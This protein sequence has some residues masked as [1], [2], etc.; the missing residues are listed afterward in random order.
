METTSRSLANRLH[1]A[2]DRTFVGRTRELARFRAALRGGHGASPVLYVHGPGGVGKSTLL[3][4]FEDEARD[5]GRRVFWVDGRR[6][7]PSPDGF[8]AEASEAVRGANIVLLVDAFEACQGLEGWLR[9][10]FLPSLPETAVVVLACRLPPGPDWSCDLAWSD[11][12]EVLSLDLL[13]ANSAGALLERRGVAPSLHDSVL[14]F[15]GGHPLALSLAA[16][17]AL[18][19][20]TKSA[21]WK[22]GPDV[23]ATLLSV[24]VGEVPSREHRLALETA[25]HALTTTETLLGAVVGEVNAAAMFAWLRNLP[26]SEY[27]RQGLFLHELVAEVLDQDFRWRDPD[28]YEQMHVRTGHHL[29]NRVRTAPEAEAMSAVRALTYLKRYG[30]MAPYFERIEREGDAYEDILRPDDYD[31]VVSM[32]LETEGEV[33][34]DIVRFWLQEQP[35]AFRTYRS[36]QT[37]ELVAYM[38]WLRLTDAQVGVSIDPVVAA[39]WDH[40]EQNSPLRVDQHMLIS[41]FMIYPEAYGEVST[42][43]HLMQL[44]ICG[45]WI[46]SRGLAWS[47]ITSP[48]AELWTPLMDHLGHRQIYQTPWGRNRVFTVFACDWRVTPMEIWFDRTQPGALSEVP[49]APV[50]DHQGPKPMSRADF[51]KAVRDALRNLHRPDVLRASPLLTS[52]LAAG[53]AWAAGEDMVESLQ[54]TLTA[55]VNEMVADPKSGK[56]HRAVATA[57]LSRIP[58]QEAAAER[59]GLPYSTYRRHLSRGLER[60]CE[61]LW[62]RE[63]GGATLPDRTAR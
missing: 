2:R 43:G 34:A 50:P 11:L 9:D 27:G 33:S 42:V 29:L 3:R 8:E 5:A 16:S 63:L 60:V 56:L 31:K 23:I 15:A 24:L 51:E 4:R 61:L 10:R 36:A 19:D 20:S 14:A 21:T 62:Q 55:A 13:D 22:P 38:L 37:G 47:F 49:T 6:I 41:R 39:A 53:F 7:D 32:A 28:S 1:S 52:R 46:R 17:V 57:Y 25:A 48:D 26:F 12:M 54:R 35:S 18:G 59:L 44:R 58:T 30:P 40:V 45:D